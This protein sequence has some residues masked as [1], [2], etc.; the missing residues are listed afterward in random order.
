MSASRGKI[1]D[2]KFPIILGHEAAGIIESVGE[3]VESLKIGDHVLTLFLPQCKKCRVCK[4]EESNTCLEFFGNQLKG[5]MDDGTTRYECKG[6]PILHFMGCST[7]S[8]YCV[9]RESSV[10]KINN[11]A[12]LDKVCLLSC[13]FTTGKQKLKNNIKYL[14]LINLGYGAAVKTTI[15]QPNSTAA[16]WGLGGI[17]LATVIGCKNAGAKR[18]IGIDP[19]PSKID[20]AKELGVTDFVNPTEVSLPLEEY[21]EKEFGAIDFTFECVGSIATMRQAFQSCA[22]GNG[23]C[24]LIGVPPQDQELSIFP[25][26]FLQGR[27]LVGELFGSYKSVDQVSSLVDEYLAGKL[28]LEKFITHTIE[29]VNIN[30]GFDLMRN[31]KCLRTVIINK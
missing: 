12:P 21:L 23:V 31:S 9:L 22:I 8:E 30:D 27:T 19:N 14:I 15:V 13:G 10:A 29:L 24:V 2:V 6:Q 26:S 3:G 5:L 7:F 4:H 25:I 1:L 28:P 20:I 11:T 17:G 18:I 16:V